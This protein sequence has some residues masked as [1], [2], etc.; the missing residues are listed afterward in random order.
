MIDFMDFPP[1]LAPFRV[2]VNIC[3]AALCVLALC[4]STLLAYLLAL[5]Q[6]IHW[7]VKISVANILLSVYVYAISRSVSPVVEMP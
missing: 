7:S 4:T 2:T 6:T 3:I 5:T 1:D